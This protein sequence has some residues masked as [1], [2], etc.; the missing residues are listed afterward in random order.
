MGIWC[1]IEVG[2]V[3]DMFQSSEYNSI[4]PLRLSPQSPIEFDMKFGRWIEYKHRR[5]GLEEDD[6]EQRV[7]QNK[8]VWNFAEFFKVCLLRRGL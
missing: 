3:L 5:S 8:K 1:Y 7:W 2:H 6:H 4:P